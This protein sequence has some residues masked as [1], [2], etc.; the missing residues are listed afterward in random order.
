MSFIKR[1]TQD[2][3][4]TIS[5]DTSYQP[6]HPMFQNAEP[7][8][9]PSMLGLFSKLRRRG[10]RKKKFKV[11]NISTILLELVQF[12]DPGITRKISK[13][14]AIKEFNSLINSHNIKNLN[15]LKRDVYKE[16]MRTFLTKIGVTNITDWESE[17]NKNKIKD[18]INAQ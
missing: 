10:R 2:I 6:Q 7:R 8:S 12:V 13:D 3:P 15:S 16:M 4:V 5:A 1:H 17:E 9:K 14:M 18:G 11:K